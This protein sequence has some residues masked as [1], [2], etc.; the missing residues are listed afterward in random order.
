MG[1]TL[2][3]LHAQY[4][5][6]HSKTLG[7]VFVEEK[8]EP[9]EIE[10]GNKKL[11]TNMT[12]N[13]SAPMEN[14]KVLKRKEPVASNALTK[15]EK[16]V[17]KQDPIEET[18]PDAKYKSYQE[19]ELS[20]V[21]PKVCI[22]PLNYSIDLPDDSKDEDAPSEDIKNSKEN[23]KEEEFDVDYDRLLPIQIHQAN[24]QLGYYNQ[25]Y[26]TY[27]QEAFDQ[28]PPYYYQSNGN[29]CPVQYMPETYYNAQGDYRNVRM[30]YNQ[31]Y[32]PYK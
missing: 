9:K 21:C 13:K 31:F 19:K 26:P 20:F 14:M 12:T 18:D 25:Y 15:P 16:N 24:E 7:P 30:P 4:I 10:N 2:E 22:P 11:D 23:K 27:P 6:Q 29:Q 28:T 1:I 5:K 3:E 17:T 8:Q 32:Q